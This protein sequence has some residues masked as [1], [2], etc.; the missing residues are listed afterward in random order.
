MSVKEFTT[1]RLSDDLGETKRRMPW[2]CSGSVQVFESIAAKFSHEVSLKLWN[3]SR[4]SGEAMKLCVCTKS[5]DIK[6]E[7]P[8]TYWHDKKKRKKKKRSNTK[9]TFGRLVI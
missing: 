2:R 9:P 5:A 1:Q 7:S 8:K 6:Y 3:W 4:I